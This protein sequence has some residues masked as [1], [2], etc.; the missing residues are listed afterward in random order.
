M[1][2]STRAQVLILGTYH[3][4]GGSDYVQTAPHDVL[5]PHRQREM[6]ELVTA[7]A[8]SALPLGGFMRISFLSLVALSS[9]V[10]AGPAAAQAAVTTCID[11]TSSM[12]TGRC[13]S[14]G[15]TGA[16][17]GRAGVQARRAPDDPRSTPR[18]RYGNGVVP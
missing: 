18:P 1:P 10:L 5:A 9:I 3:M 14:A 2:A 16:S 7:L 6:E 13:A 8:R 12:A 11:G 17:T 4:A 15:G